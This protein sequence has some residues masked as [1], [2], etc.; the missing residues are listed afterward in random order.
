MNKHLF[1]AICLLSA[2]FGMTAQTYQTGYFLDNY[3]FGYRINPAIAADKAFL[4]IGVGNITPTISSDLGLSSVLFKSPNGGLVTGL[5]SSVSS[6]EF[7][8]GLRDLNT[9]NANVD[10]NILSI[11]KWSKEKAFSTF[12]VN[13]RGN[14]GAGIPKDL[15]A[16]L[17]NGGGSD[18]SFNLEGMNVG[19]KAFAEVAIGRAFVGKKLS[20]GARIKGLVGLANATLDVNRANMTINSD[21]VS[22][23]I[24]AELDAALTGL[25]IGSKV[26]E[27]TGKKIADFSNISFDASKLA[28]CGFGAAI[29]LGASYTFFDKLTVSASIID[30]GGISWKY[31]FKA[32]TSGTQ[33]FHGVENISLDNENIGDDLDDALSQLKNLAEFQTVGASGRKME[34]LPA[35]FNVGARMRIIKMLS[36][37]Y[38]GTFSVGK[39]NKWMDNRLGAT[40]TP[41]R[42]LSLASNIGINS[43]GKA[44]GAAASVN[45]LGLNVHAG[46][47]G[48]LGPIAKIKPDNVNIP[49][50]GYIP[51]PVNSFKYAGNV[52]VNFTFGKRHGTFAKQEKEPKEPK[53]GKSG[54]KK[55]E[56]PLEQISTQ[57]ENGMTTAEEPVINPEAMKDL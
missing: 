17:K 42:W 8:G 14:A 34:M 30:L 5:N 15:F 3:S 43:F 11:G 22:Y 1:S 47:D 4:G 56:E 24:D 19:G 54:K 21:V 39:N 12:E 44:W 50:L 40:I 55:G 25:S 16:F 37:G 31:N 51:A 18:G 32:K 48:Y 45:L 36:V 35:S 29:D 7:L 49:V 28:P 46:F 10:M 23:N 27:N 33:E 26:S 9:I 41:V 20:I 53:A 52:G 38:L 2:G 13:V 57:D 6:S